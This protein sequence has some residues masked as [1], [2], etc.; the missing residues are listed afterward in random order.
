MMTMFSKLRHANYILIPKFCL[1]LSEAQMD[2]LL[3]DDK[4][5]SKVTAGST[6]KV[7]VEYKGDSLLSEKGPPVTMESKTFIL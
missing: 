6:D 2:A 4:M 3:M 1:Q 7:T 5:R